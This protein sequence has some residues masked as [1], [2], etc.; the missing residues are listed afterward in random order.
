VAESPLATLA[1]ILAGVALVQGRLGHQVLGQLLIANTND[2]AIAAAAVVV[3]GTTR[4]HNAAAQVALRTA[5][6]AI[7]AHALVQGEEKRINRR[8][9]LLHD[10][11]TT[12]AARDARLVQ[13]NLDLE[14][15]MRALERDGA[16]KDQQI[17][18]LRAGAERPAPK[19]RA[20]RKKPAAAKRAKP[21]K[22][23]PK[24][25]GG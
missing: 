19:R 18:E 16:Q 23:P 7:A 4:T 9:Q 10:R 3:A 5:A 11:E 2:A 1:R 21:A 8:E 22:R 25:P 24:K 17:A 6:P 13:Q 20:A 14:I 12:L 15:K